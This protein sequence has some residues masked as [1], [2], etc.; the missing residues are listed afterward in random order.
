MTRYIL[1]G[2]GDRKSPDYG[3]KLAAEVRKHH[4]GPLHVL[5]CLFAEPREVWETKFE[6]RK[7]WFRQVFGP[8]TEVELAFPDKFRAQAKA[9]DLIYLHGG[10]DVLLAHYLDQH[11]DIEQLFAGKIV[12]GSSAGADWLSSNYWTCDWREAR[13]GS[14]LTPANIMVHYNSDFGADTPRGAI[15]WQAAEA[16]LRAKLKPDDSILRLWEGEFIAFD[17]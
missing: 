2:G 5:S 16:E 10:D 7:A 17:F 14:G 12:V 15:D 6:Q 11:T 8:E 1:A 9:A 3:E 13:K 4:E